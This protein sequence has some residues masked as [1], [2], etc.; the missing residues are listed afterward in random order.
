MASHCLS[1]DNEVFSKNLI[2][3]H[4]ASCSMAYPQ[5]SVCMTAPLPDRVKA[6]PRWRACGGGR[7]GRPTILFAIGGQESTPL[8]EQDLD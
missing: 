6:L 8:P 7:P 1:P 3:K 2:I 5:L 4:R